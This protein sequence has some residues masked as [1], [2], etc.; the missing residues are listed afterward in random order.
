MMGVENG[1]YVSDKTMGFWESAQY[2]NM[3]KA[4]TAN[5]VVFDKIFQMVVPYYSALQTPKDVAKAIV[6]IDSVKKTQIFDIKIAKEFFSHALPESVQSE[7]DRGQNSMMT[8]KT[9]DNY[10]SK[11]DEK[12]FLLRVQSIMELGGKVV[13]LSNLTDL[14]TAIKEDITL[15]AA[16]VSGINKIA[17]TGSNYTFFETG[18]LQDMSSAIESVIANK[19][20]ILSK[21]NEI[22]AK[23]K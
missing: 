18:K 5:K 19:P 13:K 20:L 9:F 22:L 23:R 14:N 17:E 4:Y 3:E 2:K 21:L 7:K 8:R 6:A 11:M 12:T 10:T 1:G 16:F 15:R